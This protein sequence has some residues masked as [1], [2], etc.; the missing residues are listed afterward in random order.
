MAAILDEWCAMP[1]VWRLIGRNAVPV[2]APQ[3]VGVQR[4]DEDLI[5][6]LLVEQILDR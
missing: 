2:R 4:V 6:T 5:A 1:V 3:A